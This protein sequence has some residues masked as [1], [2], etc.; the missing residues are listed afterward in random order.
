MKR[1]SKPRQAGASWRSRTADFGG[2]GLA[3]NGARN[4][5]MRATVEAL[6][7]SA[8]AADPLGPEGDVRPDWRYPDD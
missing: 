6:T 1:D 4:L 5:A 3:M 7:V 8:A 2:M